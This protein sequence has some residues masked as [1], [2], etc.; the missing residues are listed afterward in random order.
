[1]KIL[2]IHGRA[3]VVAGEK[4]LWNQRAED[5]RKRGHQIYIPQ[6]DNSDD[7]R[8]EDWATQLEDL[9]VESYDCILAVSHGS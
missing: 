3:V 9:N 1:M 5:I 2:G 6:L 8:Y 7:P 4:T